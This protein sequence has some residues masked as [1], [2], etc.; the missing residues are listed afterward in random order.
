MRVG[1]YA[2][3]EQSHVYHARSDFARRH[4][5]A[6]LLDLDAATVCSLLFLLCQRRMATEADGRF[7]PVTAEGRRRGKSMDADAALISQRTCH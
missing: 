2:P 6:L 5:L 4:R 1:D 7:E 3:T